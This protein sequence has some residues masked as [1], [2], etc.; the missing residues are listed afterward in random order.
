V[1]LTR[2]YISK[3]HIPPIP[4]LC[5]DWTDFVLGVLVCIAELDDAD[6]KIVLGLWLD[7]AIGMQHAQ[8]VAFGV[9]VVLGDGVVQKG[10]VIDVSVVVEGRRAA[11]CEGDE[12][13]QI[14]EKEFHDSR[15]V[16]Q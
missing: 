7:G 14:E 9:G 12:E 11:M 15:F 4:R 8:P 6:S 10:L 1:I 16:A 13:E 3:R 5:E 2:S